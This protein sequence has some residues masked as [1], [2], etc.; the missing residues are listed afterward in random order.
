MFENLVIWWA[1]V[2]PFARDLTEA[3]APRAPACRLRC[4]PGHRLGEP[5]ADPEGGRHDPRLGLRLAQCS[6]PVAPPRASVAAAGTPLLH[7]TP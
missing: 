1:S 2:P 5:G 4:L 7:P 3:Q 6:P